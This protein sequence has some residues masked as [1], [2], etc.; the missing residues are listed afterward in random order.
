MIWSEY[1]EAGSGDE[2]VAMDA[3]RHTM[4][5]DFDWCAT[6]GE[7]RYPSV[8]NDT[9]NIKWHPEVVRGGVMHKAHDLYML[10]IM[11]TGADFVER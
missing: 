1:A 2:Q 3:E 4:L 7:G 9:G 11:E 10:D 5:V 8:L 6:D